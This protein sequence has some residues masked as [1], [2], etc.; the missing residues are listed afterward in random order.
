MIIFDVMLLD[1]SIF[2]NLPLFSTLFITIIF[3]YFRLLN[4]RIKARRKQL[5]QIASLLEMTSCE[6]NYAPSS[7]NQKQS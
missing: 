4:G 1:K 6:T 5:S 7:S 3:T 2:M